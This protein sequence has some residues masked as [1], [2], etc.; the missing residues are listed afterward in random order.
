[1]ENKETLIL[2]FGNY[3]THNDSV[4]FYK[5]KGD[6]TNSYVYTHDEHFGVFLRDLI[7]RYKNA[8]FEIVWDYS[9]IK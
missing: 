9:N 4:L 7:I 8:G 2:K 5:I 3:G 1:M 6:V